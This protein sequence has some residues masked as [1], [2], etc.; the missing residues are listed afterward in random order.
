M[1]ADVAGQVF[2]LV[3]RH[4]RYHRYHHVEMPS[5]ARGQR[6]CEVAGEHLD[7]VLPCTGTRIRIDVC[8]KDPRPWPR[9]RERNGYRT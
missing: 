5:I 4:V 3:G 9:S 1:L 8:G 2:K 7:A 6:A